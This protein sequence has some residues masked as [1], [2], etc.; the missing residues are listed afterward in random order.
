[1]TNPIKEFVNSLTIKEV[2]SI[3]HS[4]DKCMN[5]NWVTVE[6]APYNKYTSFFLE[7]YKLRPTVIREYEYQSLLF[8]HCCKRL[9]LYYIYEKYEM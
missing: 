7:K 6:E 3:I 5:E 4:Y 8:D 1:M 2:I 9:A